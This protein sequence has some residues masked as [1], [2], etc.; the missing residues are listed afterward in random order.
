MNL[1]SNYSEFDHSLHAQ[2]STVES[3]QSNRS[4]SPSRIGRMSYQ[5]GP[6]PPTPSSEI[7]HCITTFIDTLDSVPPTLT[8]SLSDLKELDAVLSGQSCSCAD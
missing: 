5:N 6:P 8:R 7:I 3:A 1:S 2:P 4:A